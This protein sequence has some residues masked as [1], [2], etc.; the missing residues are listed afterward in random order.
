MKIYA[1]HTKSHNGHMYYLAA[2]TKKVTI[3]CFVVDT[4]FYKNKADIEKKCA[5]SDC[6]KLSQGSETCV[7]GGRKLNWRATLPGSKK[8]RKTKEIKK[9]QIRYFATVFFLSNNQ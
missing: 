9:H 5:N 4:N 3:I 6:C 8:G 2:D 7:V 1:C